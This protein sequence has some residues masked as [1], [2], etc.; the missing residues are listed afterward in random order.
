M[1]SRVRVLLVLLGAF[2]FGLFAAWAKG[3]NTDGLSTISQLRSDLGNLSTPWLMVAFIAGVQS[4]RPRSGAVLGLL[5]TMSALL[6]FYLLTSLVVDLGGHGIG[7]NLWRELGANR[8]YFVS[9]A[10]SGPLFGALGAWW[11]ATRSLGAS[12]VAGALM[13]G[14]PIVLALIGVVFPATV[15]G[16]NSISVAVYAAELALGLVLLLVARGRPSA[17]AREAR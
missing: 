11:R 1:S 8:V 9:G 10:L 12:V 2:A 17:T 15:V 4:R 7:D 3:Q 14:E 16:R 6:G 5:A 13:I